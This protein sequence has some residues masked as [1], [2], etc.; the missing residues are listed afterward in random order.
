MTLRAT[1][2]PPADRADRAA[3]TAAPAPAQAPAGPPGPPPGR[4]RAGVLALP[5][6][7]AA[8]TGLV[9]L[10]G[11]LALTGAAGPRLLLDP[12][13]LARWGGP[14]VE[15]VARS[16]ATVTVG[17]LVLAS[18]VLPPGAALTAARRAA[19]LAALV[20]AVAQ[21]AV[22]PLSA[23]DVAGDR[24]TGGALAALLATRPGVMLLGAALLAAL[25]AALAGLASRS[26]SPALTGITALVALVALAPVTGAGHAH[27]DDGA[28]SALWLHVG[29]VAA[30]AG[31]LVVL[32]TLVLGQRA[33][34][35][36]GTGAG[37]AGA[38]VPT[39]DLADGRLAAVAKRYSAIA[40]VGF[41]LTAASGAVVAVSR[42]DSPDQLVTTPWG[43]VL[44]AKVVL[45]V[46]LGA[47]GAAHRRHTLPALRD[48]ARGAFARLAAGEIVL[49]AGAVGLSVALAASSPPAVPADHSATVPALAPL[50]ALT[51]WSL[52]PV[53][54]L[55]AT[56]GL[57]AYGRWVLRLRRR[58]DAWPPGR[59]L[60]WATGMVLLVW[61]TSGA[62][63]VYGHALL[64]VHMLQHMALVTFLPLLYVLGAPVSLA[65]RALPRRTDGSRGP[66]EWLLAVVSSRVAAVLLHPVVATAN[67]VV[68]MAV[69]Y[70]TP[71]AGWS[72]AEPAV[73]LLAAAHFTLAGYV[74]A[75]LLIGTD[76]VRRPPYPVR[77]LMLAPAMVVHTIL[78]LVLVTSERVLLAA[79]ESARAVL[80][81]APDLLT[82]QRAAG[83]V[84]WALGEVPAMGIALAV[85][86]RWAAAD[87]R[88][89]RRSARRHGPRPLPRTGPRVSP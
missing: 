80:V 81:A 61:T 78:G 82:D 47:A 51:Q 16:G 83:A 24:G 18:V 41:A 50:A 22:V 29:A 28:G 12:G 34:G 52:E 71:V 15:L 76:P 20:W 62:P 30:W 38:G 21:A 57:V 35:R 56:V 2:P 48:G 79:P 65:L 43:V 88:A 55:A 66:R 87:E 33:A 3:G 53:A 64:S 59:S 42:L 25:T 7:V 1:T 14:T 68:S 58:G 37:P 39:A 46:L 9:G 86:L 73:H 44:L 75:D 4:T 5:L 32:V 72:L 13:P 74:F 63:G 36:V 26:G 6:A 67:V 23:L 8:L 77:L 54:A 17:A 84:M 31:G 60:A 19:T 70:L 85:A 27:G 49:M 40:G 11:G 89:S 69:F 45:L 10:V